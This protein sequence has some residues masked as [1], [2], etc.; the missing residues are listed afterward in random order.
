MRSRQAADMS[1]LNVIDVLLQ[2]HL[3]HP[4]AAKGNIVAYSKSQ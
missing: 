3:N 1:R 2:G 4:S